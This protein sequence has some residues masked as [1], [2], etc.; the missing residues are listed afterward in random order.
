MIRKKLSQNMIINI[1]LM[2]IVI[3]YLLYQMNPKLCAQEIEFQ[4]SDYINIKGSNSKKIFKNEKKIELKNLKIIVDEWL[5]GEKYDNTLWY[6][7]DIDEIVIS[8]LDVIQLGDDAKVHHLI[9]IE[10]AKKVVIQS[11]KFSGLSK[12]AL[13][14]IEGANEV[15]V[16]GL[17][18]SGAMI[19]DKIISCGTGLWIDNGDSISNNYINNDRYKYNLDYL[20]IKNSFF[21][22]NNDVKNMN[23][24]ALLI[25]SASSGLIFN[26]RFENWNGSDASLDVSHRRSDKNYKNKKVS[27]YNNLFL[28]CKSVKTP[29]VSDYSNDI[30]FFNNFFKDTQIENYS[31]G[32]NIYFENNKFVYSKK[33]DKESIFKDYGSINSTVNI[34]NSTI[35]VDKKLYSLINLRDKIFD[36]NFL[37]YKFKDV[38][39]KILSPNYYLVSKYINFGEE[40]FVKFFMAQS[41]NIKIEKMD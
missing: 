6:F 8:N 23:R 19:N 20:E 35:S 24:D 22:D 26:N 34:Y 38:T 18:I 39:F 2:F 7:R 12:K 5:T 4:Y 13:I 29:G 36:N 9:L 11:S 30:H 14:R 1:L 41:N 32:Y 31:I 17:E 28:N 15:Y 21:H 3:I 33:Y 16:D 37:S 27:I 40:E 10:N 25:H